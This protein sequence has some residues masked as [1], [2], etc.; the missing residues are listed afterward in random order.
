MKNIK[1]LSFILLLSLSITGCGSKKTATAKVD[2]TRSTTAE[3]TNNSTDKAEKYYAPYTGEEVSK[4]TANNAAFM[5][6]IENSSAAR[7]QSG[8]NSAD[9]VFEAMTEGGTTRCLAIFQKDKAEKIGPVRSMRTYFID[10]AYEYNLPF[11]HCGGSHDALDRIKK[12]NPMTLNEMYNGSYYWRD[13]SIKIQE[14][15]LYT[16]S[17]KLISL[18]TQKSYIKPSPIK[19][20]FNKG[21]WDTL[22]SEAINNIIIRFNGEYATAY[23]FKDGL[24][25]KSMNNVPTENKEDKKP[26]AVKNLVIQK[27][28]YRTR[29]NEE[30]LDADLVGSGDAII[31]SNGKMV[32]ATWSKADL[33][34]QTIFKDEKGNI[35]P[36]NPGKTWWHLLDQNAS[37]KTN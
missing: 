17:D 18:I 1:V 33:H 23:T 3:S 22:S 37:L 25:Y 7:P 30:Y 20:A 28:N 6:I 9:I 26:V 11:A 29:P 13:K 21:Y 19:L 31:Y 5:S 4:E 34:S 32:K 12:E 14:H 10:L 2:T 36:L 27:V 15:S 8:F 16:S 24:Y 35:V